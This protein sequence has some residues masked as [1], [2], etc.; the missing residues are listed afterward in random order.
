MK[1]EDLLEIG[2]IP[3]GK[4]EAETF[5]QIVFLPPFN[6]EIQ[7]LSGTLEKETFT[8]FANNKT[9]TTKEEL[10]QVIDV[11]GSKIRRNI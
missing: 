3:F 1:H 6:F 11:I 4:V 7:T 8:L 10:K 5:Y 9:Y 2:F